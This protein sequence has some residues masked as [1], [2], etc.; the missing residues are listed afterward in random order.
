MKKLYNLILFVTFYVHLVQT[1]TESSKDDI[2]VKLT[3][4]STERIF[5]LEKRVTE[6]ERRL[7]ALSASASASS[8][9]TSETTTIVDKTPI[10]PPTLFNKHF[11]E[12][13]SYSHVNIKH[14]D[15]QQQV[16][17]FFMQ[18]QR[19]SGFR[20]KDTSSVV[21]SVG[22]LRPLDLLVRVHRSGD[23][24]IS[25]GALETMRS[26]RSIVGDVSNAVYLPGSNLFLGSGAT[27]INP[28]IAVLAS[29]GTVT[30][31]DFFACS[32]GVNLIG[33][34]NC[35]AVESDEG[36]S[37]N[38]NPLF[39]KLNLRSS[40][41]DLPRNEVVTVLAARN[42]VQ[43]GT[44]QERGTRLVVG[45]N[46]GN[47]FVL[48]YNGTIFGAPLVDSTVE[49]NFE[50]SLSS[51]S[52][53]FET[54]ESQESGPVTAMTMSD[55]VI[56][57]AFGGSS[58]I[59][60][61][62]IDEDLNRR[63]HVFTLMTAK[64]E[65]DEN[66][67]K[68]EVQY[69]GEKTP[70]P[71]HHHH[72]PPIITSL[73]ISSSP[74]SLNGCYVWGSSSKDLFLFQLGGGNQSRLQDLLG[75]R[76]AKDST[77]KRKSVIILRPI[78][79]YN[80]FAS[81]LVNLTKNGIDMETTT[82]AA[83]ATTTDTTSTSTSVSYSSPSLVATRSCL[84]VAI[85]GALAIYNASVKGE[86]LFSSRIDI[87]DGTTSSATNGASAS[88]SSSSS[89]SFNHMES[90]GRDG[91]VAIFQRPIKPQENN[92]LFKV[93]ERAVAD[94]IPQ[95]L[96]LIALNTGN[97]R[98]IMLYECKLP[99][100][101]DK[102]SNSVESA[103]EDSSTLVGWIFGILRSPF[104]L[105]LVFAVSFYASRS[106]GLAGATTAS[107]LGLLIFSGIVNRTPISKV[108]SGLHSS[109]SSSTNTSPLGIARNAISKSR[110]SLGAAQGDLN[111]DRSLDFNDRGENVAARS[112][113]LKMSMLK[114]RQ[115]KGKGGGGG[116]RR[117][118]GEDYSSDD[119]G[120]YDNE[121]EAE[122][123]YQREQLQRHV[124][125]LKRRQMGKNIDYD[126]D[127]DEDYDEDKKGKD[128]YDSDNVGRDGNNNDY[129]S[130]EDVD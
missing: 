35:S 107:E 92:H 123:K 48:S 67:V 37:I 49:D 58:H 119:G 38:Y 126:D 81:D 80:G 50:S 72:H 77:S 15:E 9:C 39:V 114:S 100:L 3:L 29:N 13:H 112:A 110:S 84:V 109:S 22:C 86:L 17:M 89:E 90:F 68:E 79:R 26:I 61:F 11:V 91:L 53:S 88:F 47:V 52:E 14:D 95:Q 23:L 44:S 130:G 85:P 120:D 5:A 21:S 98:G 97:G 7:G 104:F 115:M 124:E 83:T 108:M 54:F 32:F 41:I 69:G 36:G 24:L 71:N 99:Y 51:S 82:A 55:V 59:K 28:G 96:P 118:L 20:C 113:Q 103:I 78:Q 94:T 27:Y 46:A 111:R 6:L 116:G 34:V 75:A 57:I 19:I 8:K 106:E 70:P 45:T 62:S 25:S 64:E 122:L 101:A 60:V 127:E 76:A 40:F 93:R 125:A 42:V 117:G 30:I 12:K 43:V 129:E 1:S 10:R 66:E 65:K 31:F 16:S 56:A 105:I 4:T 73:A 63:I 74:W 2:D 18:L 121:E 33:W 87:N 128:D 102:L